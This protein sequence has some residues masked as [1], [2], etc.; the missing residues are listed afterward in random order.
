MLINKVFLCSIIINITAFENIAFEK[1][2]FNYE[3]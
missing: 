1:N 2:V 3:K